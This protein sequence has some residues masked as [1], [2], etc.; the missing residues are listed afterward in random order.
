MYFVHCHLKS[1]FVVLLPSDLI[2]FVDKMID[3]CIC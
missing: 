3:L 1:R 2:K